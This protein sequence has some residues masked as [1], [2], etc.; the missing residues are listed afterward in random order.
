VT[1]TRPITRFSGVLAAVAA[2]LAV[3]LHVTWAPASTP[4]YGPVPAASATM[5]ISTPVTGLTDG[6]TITWVVNTSG[7]VTLNL[8]EAKICKTGSTTYTLTQYSYSGSTGLRCVYQPGIQSGGFASG[9]YRHDPVPFSSVQTS[10]SMSMTVGTGTVSWINAG[11]F[12]PTSLTCDSS[13]PC[14]LVV[15]VGVTG[16]SVTDTW[17][18]QPLSFGGGGVTTTTA[19]ATTTTAAATTTTAAATTTTAAATT[20]TAAATTTT[21]AATTTT[22]AAPTTTITAPA[23]STVTPSSVAPGGTITVNSNGWKASSQVNAVLHSDPVT[24]GALTAS[25]SGV[26]NGQFSVPAGTP[27]GSHTVELTG[28]DPQD[29]ARTV[30]IPVTV[31]TTTAP[32][33]TAPTTGAPTTGGTLAFT[34]SSTRDLASVGLLLLAVG[35]F[36]LGRVSRR[37]V[38]DTP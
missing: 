4:T 6:S 5:D 14:D 26:V 33:T 23:G 11:G 22:A 19:A 9:Q 15:H 1:R 21:A 16:D 27:A 31:S 7:A 38:A 37:R 3:A 32:T 17:F 29:A 30:A 24:L 18:I 35:L 8:V 12:G 25:A 2:V 28:T 36:L 10:G 20:T 13:N 34:G